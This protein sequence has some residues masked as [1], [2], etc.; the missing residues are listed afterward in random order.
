MTEEQIEQALKL[1][2]EGKK[3]TEIAAI[4]GIHQSSI[5]RALSKFPDSR[6][7][8]R[9]RLIAAADNA[10]IHVLTAM[11]QAAD[12]GDGA[13]ALEVLDRL[14]VLPNKKH[15]AGGSGAPQVVVVVGAPPNTPINVNALPVFSDDDALPTAE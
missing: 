5:S 13:V 15:T 4:M 9:R 8:A 1:E 3:Q 11:K 12:R 2:S 10:A 6:V 14:D 7:T